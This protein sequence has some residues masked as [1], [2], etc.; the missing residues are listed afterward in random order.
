MNKYWQ[1]F[2]LFAVKGN[3]IDLAVAVIIGGAFGKTISSLVVDIIMPVV[4]VILGGINF[5]TWI[6]VLKEASFAED[7]EL[8]QAAVAINIG[9][10]IQNIFD[11]LIIAL[12]VFL[13]VKIVMRSKE[14]FFRKE[15]SEKK[16]SRPVKVLTE[17]QKLLVEIRDILKDKSK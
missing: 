9:S 3:V 6:W 14:K 8:I 10:F 17:E 12:S 15:K 4:G 11:F 7:G 13:M 2:R 1:E 16:E 5:K